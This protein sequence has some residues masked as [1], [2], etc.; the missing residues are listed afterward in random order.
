MPHRARVTRGLHPQK[1]Y[2]RY[3][4]H[5]K[6]SF[7]TPF[8]C[9]VPIILSSEFDSCLRAVLCDESE[10]IRNIDDGNEL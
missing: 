2:Y 6:V 9:H 8:K 5:L 3:F 1:M 10:S 4:S 7:V